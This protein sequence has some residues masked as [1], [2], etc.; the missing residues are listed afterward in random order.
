M[1]NKNLKLLCID[2]G[3]K[4]VGLAIADSETKMASPFKILKNSKDL[5]ANIS[6][7]CK[8]EEIDKIVIGVPLGLKGNKSEQYERVI[9]FI[10]KLKDKLDLPIIEQ[11]EKLTSQYAQRLLKDTKS[12]H[13]DDDVAAMLILQS[14]LDER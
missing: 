10:K 1:N 12:K 7:I 4:N 9:I 5:L 2:Y 11:D 14:Y 8:E 13:V 3:A 6:N